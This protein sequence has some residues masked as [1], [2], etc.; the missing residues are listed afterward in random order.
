[1]NRKHWQTDIY[2]LVF[3]I[4]HAAVSTRSIRAN[5]QLCK[6]DPETIKD[7][8]VGEVDGLIGNDLELHGPIAQTV[9]VKRFHALEHGGPR[10]LVLMEEVAA[11]QNEV[12]LCRRKKHQILDVI[13]EVRFGSTL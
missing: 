10:R 13:S 6:Q 12:H 7:A 11:Q 4:H 9:L 8:R 1:M 3:V 5:Q 2:I